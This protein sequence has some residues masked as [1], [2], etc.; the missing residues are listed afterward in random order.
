MRVHVRGCQVGSKQ[1]L[2]LK[3]DRLPCFGHADARIMPMEKRA[4][5]LLAAGY[6]S[7]W[8]REEDGHG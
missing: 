1:E 4:G 3:N 2:S 6:I 5:F 8:E 7:A